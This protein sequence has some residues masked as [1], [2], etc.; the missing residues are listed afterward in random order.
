MAI[1]VSVIQGKEESAI[2][3]LTKIAQ[4]ELRF[5]K[6]KEKS[7]FESSAEKRK[8]VRQE[9]ARRKSKR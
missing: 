2:K 7:Y 9:L 3:K 8:R 5:K 4:R 6:A 1:T